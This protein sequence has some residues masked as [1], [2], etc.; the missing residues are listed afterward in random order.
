MQM[1]PSMQLRLQ[2]IDKKI[3]LRFAPGHR[4]LLTE[5]KQEWKL[6]ENKRKPE[7]ISVI[8]WKQ[9]F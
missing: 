9:C 2:P 6:V 3:V 4:F 7:Q 1:H 8:R 5:R